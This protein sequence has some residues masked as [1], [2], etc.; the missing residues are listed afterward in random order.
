MKVYEETVAERDAMVESLAAELAGAAYQ[1][2]SRH[3][4]NGAWV[5]LELDLWRALTQ[6]IKT[7][8][9][10]GRSE[11][12]DGAA[13]RTTRK[14]VEDHESSDSHESNPRFLRSGDSFDSRFFGYCGDYL[15]AYKPSAPVARLSAS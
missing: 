11:P 5:D 1:V 14:T 12:S 13:H 2:R 3:E 9:S 4:P 8:E 7:W 15:C 6:A 10:T